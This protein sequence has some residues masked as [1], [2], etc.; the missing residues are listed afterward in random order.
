MGRF[1]RKKIGDNSQTINTFAQSY[2]F[3]AIRQYD[4]D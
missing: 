3:S 4:E 1:L 2:D